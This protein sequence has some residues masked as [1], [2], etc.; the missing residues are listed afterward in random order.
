[1]QALAF[2]STHYVSSDLSCAYNLSAFCANYQA[3]IF[4]LSG[5]WSNGHVSKHTLR[6]DKNSSPVSKRAVTRGPG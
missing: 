4:S 3:R 6:L 5:E 2:S 1:M